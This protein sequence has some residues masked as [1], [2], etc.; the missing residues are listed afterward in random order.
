MDDLKKLIDNLKENENETGEGLSALLACT[1]AGINSY[2]FAA[3]D[4]IRR[5]NYLNKIYIRGLIEIS[6]YCKNNCLYCGIRAG[7]KK[8]ERYRLTKE[9]ILLCCNT[10]YELGFR[11]FVMQGGEDAKTDDDF[12]C[13]VVSDIKRLYPDV[14]VTLS[15]GEKTRESY[16]KFYDAGAD[17][18]LLRHETATKT[19][20]EKLHPASMSYD[21]RVRCLYDLKEIG[22]QVGCGIMV[23]SP[24][25]TIEHLVSD[26]RFMQDLKPQ[27]IG[28]GPFITHKDTPFKDFPSGDL[29][30]TLRMLA[31]TRLMFPEIL[32][33]AT[34][35]LGSI[36]SNGRLLGLK[37][38]CNVVMPNLSPS[39]VR[40]LY[41]LYNNKAYTGAEA[42]ESL[43]ILKTMAKNAGYEVVSDRGDYG[44]IHQ[45]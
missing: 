8:P 42:A 3:A 6:S 17:R 29:Y 44:R 31:I 26:L 20:Y 34:T 21:N 7:N 4:E 39:D 38:G 11:T 13:S 10:G 14:A 45:G 24:Y 41:T 37:A 5:K 22:Y 25:Q 16:K 15:L 2:L 43:D 30:L 19:H 23:G 32:L 9:E 12:I 28:I 40:Q 27:M 33:P 18:Y 1:D 35:A 36:D